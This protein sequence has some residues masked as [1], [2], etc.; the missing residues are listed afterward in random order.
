MTPIKRRV[1]LNQF[2]GTR[3]GKF[4]FRLPV[5][6]LDE[7]IIASFDKW[8][9]SLEKYGLK[10]STGPVVPFRAK[11]FLSDNVEPTGAYVPLLWMNNVRAQDVSWPL[12]DSGKQQYI[13]WSKQSEKLLVPVSNYVLIRRFSTKKETRRLIAAP[14]FGE[15]FDFRFVGLENHLNFIYRHEGTLTTEE[16]VGISTML[17]CALVDRY[18][19][20][21]N[22]NTQV[23]AIDL[24]RLPLSSLGV[25]KILGLRVLAIEK[26]GLNIDIDGLT[27]SIIRDSGYL[28]PDFPTIRE[29]RYIMGARPTA[30]D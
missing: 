19:R 20:I 21:I 15:K 10:V 18:F 3:D 16:S 14:L 13:E 7:Q 30:G 28:P 26:T 23:N 11:S 17:N 25:I 4:F 8:E 1:T 22:G 5:G 24:R 9:G 2:L 27:F 6:E 12:T 29:T